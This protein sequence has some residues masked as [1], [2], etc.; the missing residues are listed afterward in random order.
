M[1]FM[2]QL[3]LTFKELLC[4]LFKILEFPIVAIS[5]FITMLNQGAKQKQKTVK[6]IE[7]AFKT[8]K[9]FSFYKSSL[10]SSSNISA[11]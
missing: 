1:P 4:I 7:S 6:H 3:C 11:L 9:S 8:P 2:D 5:L 10:D